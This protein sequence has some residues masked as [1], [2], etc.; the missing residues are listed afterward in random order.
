MFFLSPLVVAGVKISTFTGDDILLE[1]A[2]QSD[3]H[4]NLN[5][6]SGV[7]IDEIIHYFNKQGYSNINFSSVVYNKSPWNGRPGEITFTPAISM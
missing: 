4:V 2:A 5:V 6:G 1:E 7:H 3:D